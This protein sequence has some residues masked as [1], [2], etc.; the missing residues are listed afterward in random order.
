VVTERTPP[1]RKVWRT[2]G[3]PRLLVISAYEMDFALAPAPRGFRLEVWIDYVVARRPLWRW[4]AALLA[5]AYA[6]WC[7]RQMVADAV[8]A[9]PAPEN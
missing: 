1:A 3:E 7:V 6:R 2:T 9:F 4:L 8:K 5:A